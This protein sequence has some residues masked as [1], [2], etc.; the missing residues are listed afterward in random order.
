MTIRT[1]DMSRFR[2]ANAAADTA[3]GP[4]AAALLI[5]GFIHLILI[6]G[7]DLAFPKASPDAQARRPLEIRVLQRRGPPNEEPKVADTSAQ[8]APMVGD[9]E[10]V[11]ETDDTTSV[12]PAPEIPGL[13]PLP[14][15]GET[16]SASVSLPLP[17]LAVGSEAKAVEQTGEPVFPANP[18]LESEP[19]P[20]PILEPRPSETPFPE[21]ER[22]QV[23]AAEILASRNLA[24][25]EL[26][27][28][29]RHGSTTSAN[30]PRRK[31]IGTGTREYK[32]ANYLEAWCRKVEQVGNLNY[33]EETKRRKLYGNLTLQVALRA[34]GSVER[35]RVLRSSGFD[36]LDE[37]AV[38]IVELAAPFS[39]FP[40]A[41]RAETDILDITRTWRFL[42]NNRLDWKR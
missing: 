3:V 33:P 26:T 2:A 21:S 16:F 34:D 7:V 13:D 14:V 6:L 24:V 32:Y 29:I 31:A 17:G 41:I 18:E 22:P 37:A 8:T 1:G 15:L 9:G 28:R 42:G 10:G 20:Q 4:F 36:L 25:A 30:R 40:P 38:R 27:A 11:R 5:A 19:E 23:E 35:V 12:E 39:P